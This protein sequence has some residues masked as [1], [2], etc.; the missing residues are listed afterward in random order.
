[1]KTIKIFLLIISL[2][3]PHQSPAKELDKKDI[4]ILTTCAVACYLLYNNNT[5]SKS[6]NLGN[7]TQ[8]EY[9]INHYGNDDINGEINVKHLIV[10]LYGNGT[11][12]LTGNAKKQE[13][14]LFGNCNYNAK[15]LKSE[16]IR[17]YVSGNG[18]ALLNATNNISGNVLGN[19]KIT[20]KNNPAILIN[21]SGN[22]TIHKEQPP[23]FF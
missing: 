13:L 19:V 9:T 2:L 14:N 4:A 23:L 7:I 22:G 16:E 15:N 21:K 20:Y 18:T 8:E 12:T 6:V 1:M 5:S 3:L 17:V 11:I 10:N